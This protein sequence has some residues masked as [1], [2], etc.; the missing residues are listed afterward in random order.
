M[1]HTVLFRGQ[2]SWSTKVYNSH[3]VFG[4]AANA[5]ELQ[6]I[7]LLLRRLPCTHNKVTVRPSY[8][9]KNE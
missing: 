9:N 3:Y 2:R 4:S 6:G 8:D 1:D 7:D 5:E